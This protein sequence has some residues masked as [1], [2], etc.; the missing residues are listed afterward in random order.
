MRLILVGNLLFAVM[1]A[2]AQPT[3]YGAPSAHL[4]SAQWPPANARSAR[5]PS[6][7]LPSAHTSIFMP[8]LWRDV[9]RAELPLPEPV[10]ITAT[11]TKSAGPIETPTATTFPSP[12]EVPLPTAT[13]PPLSTPTEVPAPTATPV[14]KPG[15]IHGKITVGGE[16]APDGF[17]I[18][19]YPKLELRKLVGG[20]WQTVMPAHTH[21]GGQF[22]FED[23][24][25]LSTGEVYQVW[26][27][28][29]TNSDIDGA[30]LW[31]SRWWSRRLTSF[32][33]G[34]DVDLGVFEVAN[35]ELTKPCNDCGQTP[36]IDFM[37]KVRPN[38][39]EV[40]RWSLYKDCGRDETRDDSYRSGPLGHARDY[41]MAAPPPGFDLNVRYC[42]YIFIEDGQNGTGWTFYSHKVMFLPPPRSTGNSRTRPDRVQ[43]D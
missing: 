36:P 41:Q 43:L 37:W 33:P 28:N 35:L 42:W 39:K 17:G 20:E 4:F 24:P 18:D 8:S 1:A 29:N 21:D 9:L 13:L 5:L 23:V 38:G 30:Y 22:E 26:F 14:P 7:Q 40:Y 27:V 6:A 25:A 16:P 12:T 34:M 32:N 19:P 31:L 10:V 11:P 2:M 15:R 3:L